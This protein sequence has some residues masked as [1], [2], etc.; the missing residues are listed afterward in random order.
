MPYARILVI[1]G[2]KKKGLGATPD[3]ESS[4][5]STS[6]TGQDKRQEECFLDEVLRGEDIN[7]LRISEENLKTVVCL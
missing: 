4:H 1:A 5:S 2:S 3:A 7:A 6:S